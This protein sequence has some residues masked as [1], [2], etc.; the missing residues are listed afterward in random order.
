MAAECE[1]EEYRNV[2]DTAE[3]EEVLDESVLGRSRQ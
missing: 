3:P 1:G 2:C